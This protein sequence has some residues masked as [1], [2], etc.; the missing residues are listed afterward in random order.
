MSNQSIEQLVGNLEGR[1]KNLE[2]D[3]RGANDKLDKI[4]ETLATAKGG[5][6]MLLLVGT[7]VAGFVAIIGTLLG[8]RK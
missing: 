7:L 2:R 6:R 1:V 8:F 5:W 3:L 4:S